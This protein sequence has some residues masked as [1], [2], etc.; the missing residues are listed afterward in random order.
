MES[1]LA[2]APGSMEDHVRSRVF[3]GRN[4]WID[5]G[6]LRDE[7]AVWLLASNF[8][9]RMEL[10]AEMNFM[11]AISHADRVTGGTE[12]EVMLGDNRAIRNIAC[13]PV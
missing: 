11:T 12:V 3:P 9:M 5:H 10:F 8:G 2:F 13:S 6:E 4:S 1:E 7:V